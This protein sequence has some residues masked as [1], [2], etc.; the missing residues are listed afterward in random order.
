MVSLMG[1]VLVQ[2]IGLAGF[3]VFVEGIRQIHQPAAMIVGGGI[4]VAWTVLK[5]RR[6]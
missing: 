3:V 4:V 5:V 6:E 2:S 1:P